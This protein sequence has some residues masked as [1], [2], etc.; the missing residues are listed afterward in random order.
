[1]LKKETPKPIYKTFNVVK[2][3][4]ISY[5][6]R[7]YYIQDGKVIKTEDSKPNLIQYAIAYIGNTLYN[8]SKTLPVTPKEPSEQV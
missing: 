4:E 7:T 5:V 2:V 3:D 1:M 6:A 8:E